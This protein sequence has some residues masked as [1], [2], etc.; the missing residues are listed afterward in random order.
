MFIITVDGHEDQ[1]AYSAKSEDGSQ[2][3]YMFE[4]E[5]DA[6]RFAMMLEDDRDYPPMHVI[7]VDDDAILKA[8][9]ENSYE[10]NIFSEHEFVIPPEED[11][12]DFI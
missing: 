5:D 11:G 12:N 8:C 7:E 6:V 3:L 1:G 2:I 10:Y 4:E 9:R